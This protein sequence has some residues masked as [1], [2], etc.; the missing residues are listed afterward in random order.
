MAHELSQYYPKDEKIPILEKC[1]Y[2]VKEV[3]HS[4][5]QT[6]K[7]MTF[8]DL[9]THAGCCKV[10]DIM[11][12]YAN[13]WMKIEI[14]TRLFPNAEMIVVEIQ[15]TDELRNSFIY[16]SMLAFLRKIDDNILLNTVEILIGNIDQDKENE[17]MNYM[18]QYRTEFEKCSWNIYMQTREDI[19][20]VLSIIDEVPQAID[21]LERE[22]RMIMTSNNQ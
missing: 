17:V 9:K 16:N 20:D 22:V 13:G 15:D 18:K 2:Y 8:Y 6:I 21:N 19:Y 7:E 10:H 14:V 12:R 3:L 11:L 1:P 5:C 4:H